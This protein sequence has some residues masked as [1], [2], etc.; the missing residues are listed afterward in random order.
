MHL[1]SY[2][3]L[4]IDRY[5]YN[6]YSSMAKCSIIKISSA[7]QTDVILHQYCQWFILKNNEAVSQDDLV[8]LQLLILGI[9]V[10]SWL[11]LAKP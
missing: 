1:L 11:L 5:N 4:I 10:V 7:D 6:Y 3:L 8:R 2:I 9:I